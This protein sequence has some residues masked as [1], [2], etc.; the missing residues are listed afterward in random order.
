MS[1]RFKKAI[2]ADAAV[3]S[4]LRKRIWADVY[5]GIYPD[6]AIDGY[7]GS[8]HEARDRARIEDPACSVYL[9]TEGA[10][11]VGYLYFEDRGRVHIG[12][13]YMLRECR[14]QGAG[15]RAFELVRSYCR[16]NGYKTFT[17]SCNAHNAP[18][19]AFYEHI[20]G[21]EIG[22]DVG[23]ENRQEDQVKFEFEV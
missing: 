15:R 14:R 18:A 23:H 7:D 11:P 6:Q 22:R 5:R 17:C 21:R 9:I 12:S 10:T 16:E 13:L 3:I 19:L 2:P 20:G 8:Y 1:I 4:R